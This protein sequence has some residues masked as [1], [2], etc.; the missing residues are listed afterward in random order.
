MKIID[1]HWE[2]RNLGVASI[3]VNIGVADTPEDISAALANVRAQYVVI[4]LPVGK[5][6]CLLSLQATGYRFIEMMSVCYHDG[7]LPELNS[8]QRRLLAS[9][10][11]SDASS[12]ELDQVFAGVDQGMFRDDRVSLDPHFDSAQSV[13]RYRGWIFDEIRAGASVIAIRMKGEAVGFFILKAR[14]EEGDIFASLGGIFPKY[15][16]FGVGY[17]M[18]YLEI[19]EGRRRGAK[20]VYTAFSSNNPKITSVH[21]SM[22]Y[23]ILRQYYVLVRHNF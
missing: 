4:K 8:V 18:N 13:A 14:G 19:V 7:D 15:Q 16:N 20:R 2:K 12:E 6:D 11:Y 9:L 17:F 23:K 3:E 5:V 21:F 1:A 10:S 22:G